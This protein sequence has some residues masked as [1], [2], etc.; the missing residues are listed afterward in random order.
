LGL[1]VTGVSFHVGSGCG[2]KKAY[3]TAFRHSTQIFAYADKIGLPPMTMVDIGGGF[4]G[5][6]GGY[7]GPD[8]PTFQ[9]LALTVREAIDEFRTKVNADS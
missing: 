8:M 6:K 2:D 1:N 3:T 4:P 9:E 7:G 5:D